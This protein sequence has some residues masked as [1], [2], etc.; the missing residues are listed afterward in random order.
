MV[1]ESFVRL[2]L[3]VSFLKVAVHVRVVGSTLKVGNS[4]HVLPWI[5]VT[6][7]LMVSHSPSDGEGV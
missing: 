4:M 6:W 7:L 5:V 2:P 3:Y 1:C